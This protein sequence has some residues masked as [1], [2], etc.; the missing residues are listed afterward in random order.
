MTD[1][2]RSEL[3]ANDSADE[4]LHSSSVKLFVGSLPYDVNEED[5]I[6]VFEKFGEIEEFVILRD[7]DGRSKGCAALRYTSTS[8]ADQCI[9]TL[10]NRFC[11]GNV[12]T[13]LQV[14]YFEKRESGP[15][16]CYIEGLPFCFVPNVMWA[17]L[18][19]T[20]GPVSNVFPDSVNPFA[21]Y[22]S[23]YKKAS[24]FSL[25]NDARAGSLSI[26]GLICPEARVTVMR[27]PHQFMYPYGY[28]PGYNYVIPPPMMVSPSQSPIVFPVVDEE[29]TPE[30]PPTKLFAGCLPFSKTAQDVADLFS[31][32]GDLLEVAILTDYSGKSRG[33]AFVTFAKGSDAEKAM[34]ALKDFCFPKST[35]CINISYAYKQTI[36]NGRHR[37][38]E[39]G[40]AASCASSHADETC[41]PVSED[42]ESADIPA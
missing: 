9:A 40:T 10:H 3:H 4:G 16:T 7:R 12:P 42:K 15:V 27:Q 5:L 19:G 35:R 18:S 38:S 22:V 8:A 41:T 28:F 30:D 20:Y 33:A 1:E 29:S 37:S 25:S 11:C 26:G 36:W 23:F 34:E 2:S 6:S 13:P 14:R 39:T 24:A 17:S 31:P 21:M 32:F